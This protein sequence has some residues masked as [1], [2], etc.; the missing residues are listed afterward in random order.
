MGGVD[1]HRG[2]ANHK[3]NTK[4]VQRTKK[5]ASSSGAF[6]SDAARKLNV[7]RHDGDALG[8]DRA[9]VGIFEERDQ[10][11]FGRFLQGKD[12]RALESEIGFVVLSNFTDQALERQLA[13]QESGR[14]LVLADLAQRNGTRLPTT[15]SGRTEKI[16]T[17]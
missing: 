12:S 13:D 2:F 17:K 5:V 6:A 10:V 3:W 4:A 16:K 15:S 7:F 9:Q 8:V 11:G 14:L 1:K